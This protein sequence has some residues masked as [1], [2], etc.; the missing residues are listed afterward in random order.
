[1]NINLN[2]RVRVKLTEHGKIILKMNEYTIDKPD[3]NGFLEL[4]LWELMGVFGSVMF[5]GNPNFPFENMNV[6]L[7]T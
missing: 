1:M 6:E 7:L 5:M 2:A 4:R 3:E